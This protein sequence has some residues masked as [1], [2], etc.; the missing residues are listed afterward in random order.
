MGE[1]RL[2]YCQLD[3]NNDQQDPDHLIHRV[4][5]SPVIQ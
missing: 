2:I 4:E 1:E 5:L 3:Q